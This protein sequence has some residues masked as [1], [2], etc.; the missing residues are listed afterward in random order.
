MKL[1][2]LFGQ[3]IDRDPSGACA[4]I[5]FV[6]IPNA[7]FESARIEPIYDISN[8]KM[9]DRC[10]FIKENYSYVLAVSCEEAEELRRVKVKGFTKSKP[11]EK[12]RRSAKKADK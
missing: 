2:R 7:D 6:Y 8:K 1:K 9:K 10:H 5:D 4:G 11:N 12:R 3:I